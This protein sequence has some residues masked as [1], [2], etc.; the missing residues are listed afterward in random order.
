MCYVCREGAADRHVQ[1]VPTVSHSAGVPRGVSRQLAI[2]LLPSGLM[3]DGQSR[4]CA[5]TLFK[6]AS[7]FGACRL[8]G[9]RAHP[10]FAQSQFERWTQAV[11]CCSSGR[12]RTAL[13]S[14]LPDTSL[15]YDHRLA[16]SQLCSIDG[17]TSSCLQTREDDIESSPGWP[18][19]RQH[20]HTPEAGADGQR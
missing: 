2:T 19:Q 17:G 14:R 12:A 4:H 20:R 18:C 7:V 10:R 15:M 11:A 16:S 9:I 6:S 13:F 5:L 1:V 8:Q 3:H